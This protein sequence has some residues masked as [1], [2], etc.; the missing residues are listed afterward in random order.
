MILNIDRSGVHNYS[1]R[2][3]YIILVYN[4]FRSHTRK[5]Y[6]CLSVTCHLKEVGVTQEGRGGLTEE[7]R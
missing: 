7:G 6:V 2:F 3:E 5:V 4:V 1:A